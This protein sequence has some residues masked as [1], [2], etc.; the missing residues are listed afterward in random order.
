MPPRLLLRSVSVPL[1]LCHRHP[2]L[3]VTVVRNEIGGALDVVLDLDA[4]LGGEALHQADDLV[5]IGDAL[6]GHEVGGEAGNVGRS[7]ERCQ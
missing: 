5:D 2:S 4:G 3:Q 1:S 7:W 6:E